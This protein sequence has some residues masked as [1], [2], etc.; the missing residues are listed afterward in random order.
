MM[1]EVGQAAPDFE[2]LTDDGKTVKLSD[3]KGQQVVLYFYPAAD[4]P[5]C[6][7][8]ACAFRNDYSA[9]QSKNAA[10]LGASPDTVEAQAAFKQKYNLPFTL[11]ADADHH[12]A[13]LYGVWGTHRVTTKAGN[14]IEFT[15]ILRSSFIIGPDGKVTGVF[16]GVDPANNS[17]EM[18]AKL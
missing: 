2:V 17:Q 6:T 15:G 11:L 16:M 12:I 18:L 9:F 1:L 5:G 14:E 7:K 13:D 4:T 8:Q 3:Y 10:I